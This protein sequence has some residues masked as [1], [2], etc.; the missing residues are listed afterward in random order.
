MLEYKRYKR[1]IEI[2]NELKYRS[3]HDFQKLRTIYLIYRYCLW[4]II[5]SYNSPSNIYKVTIKPGT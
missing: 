3:I 2:V 1:S 5:A 4:L